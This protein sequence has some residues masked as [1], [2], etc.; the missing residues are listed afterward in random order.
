MEAN[1]DKDAMSTSFMR[2]N[3]LRMLVAQR[4]QY[5]FISAVSNKSGWGINALK[6][7]LNSFG[8]NQQVFPHVGC[9]VPIN[10]LVMEHYCRVLQGMGTNAHG[11]QKDVKCD[12]GHELLD[13]IIPCP[14]VCDSC[15]NLYLKGTTMF[16]CAAC[17]FDLCGDCYLGKPKD[18]MTALPSYEDFRDEQELYISPHWENSVAIHISKMGNTQLRKMCAKPYVKASVMAEA[19]A[20]CGI[21]QDVFFRSLEFLHTSGSI[22]YYGD[23]TLD[24]RLRGYLFTQPQWIIDAIKYVHYLFHRERI[25]FIV[26]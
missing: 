9:T 14:V 5:M 13:Y 23:K 3:D 16:G 19:A 26:H 15:Q 22:L 12:K 20:E 4:P 1:L 8:Q 25:V 6:F 2:L 18:T 11:Q 24:E 17:M 10:Y 21:Q 7:L